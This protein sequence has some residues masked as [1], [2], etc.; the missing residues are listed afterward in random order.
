MAY[1]SQEGRP[2]PAPTTRLRARSPPEGEA[3]S[4]SDDIV[5]LTLAVLPFVP[6]GTPPLPLGPGAHHC[7][8]FC[9]PLY[10]TPRP[11]AGWG[12]F[13]IGHNIWG[14]G[15]LDGLHAQW[16]SRNTF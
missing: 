3:A 5:E 14:V 1:L 11:V 7:E 6:P 16:P 2:P 9:R 4:S 13:E 10:P 8:L 12:C 15:Q